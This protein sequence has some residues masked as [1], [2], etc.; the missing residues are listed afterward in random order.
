MKIPP[1]GRMK[2]LLC[3]GML[4]WS[5]QKVVI[6]IRYAMK[7]PPFFWMKMRFDMRWKCHLW[8]EWRCCFVTVCCFDQSRR[9]WFHLYS[10]EDAGIQTKPGH[11]SPS[12]FKG[13]NR[14]PKNLE[15]SRP[16][17]PKFFYWIWI[18]D[19]FKWP[20]LFFFSC[21][22]DISYFFLKLVAKARQSVRLFTSL[23]LLLAIAR[24]S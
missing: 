16:F 22:V 4:L 7:T 17:L 2:M 9:W 10:N 15:F 18:V 19:G 11:L 5:K 6:S 23:S 13:L 12:F 21:P 8:V 24:A 1:L 14:S 3:Y 20:F